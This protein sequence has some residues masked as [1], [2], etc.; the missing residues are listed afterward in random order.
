MYPPSYWRKWDPQAGEKPDLFVADPSQSFILE[1][2]AAEL[3]PTEKYPTGMSLRFPKVNK[4][5]YDKS[6]D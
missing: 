4:I 6:W 2:K 1:V 5:R 3:L